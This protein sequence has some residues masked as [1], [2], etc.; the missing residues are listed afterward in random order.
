MKAT[1]YTCINDAILD[2]QSLSIKYHGT[3][4]RYNCQIIFNQLN[5]K[6]P[7]VDIIVKQSSINQ[8]NIKVPYV[9]IIDLCHSFQILGE[10]YVS[11]HKCV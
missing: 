2:K 6:V 1:S 8:L 5:I 9:D 7:Y 10:I 3:L 11:R 4:R